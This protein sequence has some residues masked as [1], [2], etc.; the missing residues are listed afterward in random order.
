MDM[1]TAAAAGPSIRRSSPTRPGIST[2][3]TATA[4][5]GSCRGNPDGKPVG[6]PS[7]RPR[8]A[9]PAP[10]IGASSNPEQATRSS[11]ST[12]A[13]AA[14]RRRTRASRPTPP[15][16]WSTTSRRLRTRG[17][18]G[19]QVDG[20]RR[21]LGLDAVARLCRRPTERVTELVLRGIFLFEQYELDW[22]Y[23]EGGA[24][25]IYPDKWDEFIALD[26]R[27]RARRPG[28]GLSQ[29]AD[30]RRPDEQLAPPRRGASGKATPSPCSRSPEIDR[31]FHRARTRRSPSPGSRTITWPQAAG[32]RK[33]SCC[34][35]REKLRGIPGVIVQGRHDSCTPPRAAWA[36]KK[37]W[38]EVELQDRPRRR[39]ICST[40]RASSTG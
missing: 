8:R 35:T 26:P 18:E 19:R 6:V 1:H 36:L 21:Q 5:I 17:R 13:A 14:G 11:C 2:S 25:S 15:G 4:S 40:S 10:T 16:T 37:A 23:K 39:A 29:A 30:R 38:P 33:G 3:A 31:G 27:G 28:R 22:L 12:S 32:S 34:A 7:R 24:S 20:V 9:A